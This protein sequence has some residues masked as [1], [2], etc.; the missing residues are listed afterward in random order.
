[1]HQTYKEFGF[2]AA[3]QTP[4]FS[5]LHGHSFLVKVFLTG[6]P[7]PVF[8]WTHNLLELEPV[9]DC[10]RSELDHR[11]LNDI[12]GLSVPTLENVARFIWQRMDSRV[13]GLERV[14]ISRGQ[15]GQSEGACYAGRS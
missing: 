14:E 2:E 4:P 6:T 11:Y 3:H 10:V 7:D 12:E 8:G 15:P 9:I 5:G 1:M 13:S